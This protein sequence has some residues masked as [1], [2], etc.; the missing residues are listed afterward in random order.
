M[1]CFDDPSYLR[2]VLG[3]QV[4]HGV[5][6]CPF[7]CATFSLPYTFTIIGNYREAGTV[8]ILFLFFF[9]A[10]RVRVEGKYLLHLYLE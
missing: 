8:S 6:F 10:L 3:G 9:S 2:G 1:I 7:V 4:F 5:M